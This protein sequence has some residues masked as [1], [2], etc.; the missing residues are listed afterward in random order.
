MLNCLLKPLVFQFQYKRQDEKQY[1]K[2]LSVNAWLI[3]ILLCLALTFRAH[4][5]DGVVYV[6]TAPQAELYLA[7]DETHHSGTILS[8]G[9][10]IESAGPVT[11]GFVPL[12]TRSGARAWIRLSDVA[13]E[14]P[15]GEFLHPVE[16]AAH[17]HVTEAAAPERSRFGV[18][19][20]TYDLGLSSGQL[21]GANYTE[22]GIGLSAYFRRWL[23]WRNEIF[24]RFTSGAS[25]AYG[26]D[27]SVRGVW[28]VGGALGFTAFAGPGYRFVTVGGNTPLVEAGLV[29]KFAGIA[30]GGGMKT[31]L[32]SWV[33]SGAANDSQYF[34]ILG[35]GGSL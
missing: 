5:A 18:E 8:Q 35:G 25:N 21:N 12:S 19:R 31:L 24:A 4:A 28:N 11:R 9:R 17:P 34:I 23:A 30:L 13:L 15:P 33:Q 22:L 2:C 29:F 14:S 3:G 32:N 26:L 27:S 10:R 7:P 16:P 1:R 20:L 6:V